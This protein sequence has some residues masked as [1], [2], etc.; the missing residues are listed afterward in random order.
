METNNQTVG[1]PT[2]PYK[3]SKKKLIISAVVGTFLIASIVLGATTNFFGMMMQNT[4]SNK[5]ATKQKNPDVTQSA[6]DVSDDLA[7][8]DSGYHDGDTYT[9]AATPAL[10]A[11]E[12]KLL[13][14]GTKLT[15]EFCAAYT[16]GTEPV[17]A[18]F[19]VNGTE[20]TTLT[21]APE[22]TNGTA[23]ASV[24]SEELSEFELADE[25][26]VSVT[27]TI[28]FKDIQ[29][30]SLSDNETTTSVTVPESA[31]EEDTTEKDLYLGTKGIWLGD[32]NDSVHAEVCATGTDGTESTQI[33]YNVNGIE[34]KDDMTAPADGECEDM[35]V[36]DLDQFSV[37]AGNTYTAS[38]ILDYSQSITESDENNGYAKDIT[39]EEKSDDQQSSKVDLY[40]NDEENNIGIEDEYFYTY[41]CSVSALEEVEVRFQTN[42]TKQVVKINIAENQC[43]KAAAKISEF[44]LSDNTAYTLDVTIDP[45]ETVTE[46]NENNNKDTY[47]FTTSANDNGENVSEK[48]LYFGDKG[49]WMDEENDSIYAEMCASG[50][51]GSE[52]EYVRINYNL[53]GIDYGYSQQAPEDGE[54]N[55]TKISGLDYFNMTNGDTYTITVTLD[56]YDVLEESDESNNTASTDATYGEEEASDSA[57]SDLYVGTISIEDTLLTIELG[58]KG[59]ADYPNKDIAKGS[60]YIYIDNELEWTYSLSTLGDQT[61]RTAGS[62]SLIQPQALDGSHEI[63]ACVYPDSSVGDADS[64][65]DCSSTKVGSSDTSDDE[66]GDE[67]DDYNDSDQ[68]VGYTDTDDEQGDT[69][70]DVDQQD[71]NTT[72]NTTSNA[73]LKKY[74]VIMMKFGDLEGTEDKDATMDYTGTLTSDS[75]IIKPVGSVL[76][77]DDDSY[78]SADLGFE[79]KNTVYDHW[80]GFIFL[81]YYDPEYANGATPT[82][83]VSVDGT[84]VTK[85]IDSLK[86]LNQTY[87]LGDGTDNAIKFVILND[88]KEFPDTFGDVDESDDAEDVADDA[89]DYIAD[90]IEEATDSIS[91]VD[92]SEGTDAETSESVDELVDAVTDVATNENTTND[93]VEDV[94]QTTDDSIA[95]ETASG[96]EITADTVDAVADDTNSA[97]TDDYDAGF[98]DVPADSWFAEYINEAEYYGIVDGYGDCNFGPNDYVTRAALV[99]MAINA[100][101]Y[102]VITD[103]AYNEYFYDL[104]DDAWYTDYINTAAYYEIISGYSNGNFGP[105]NIVNR[106]EGLKAIIVAS[107]VE[108]KG[109]PEIGTEAT[110]TNPFSDVD[111]Y[112]WYYTYVMEG[113]SAGI[114]SG[115]SGTFR[116]ADSL[117]RAEACK[118]IIE[119]MR[120]LATPTM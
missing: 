99:K 4:S 116:P 1:V 81:A 66:D 79:W 14:D 46:A 29:E 110:W 93:E 39:I 107:G 76:L 44:G 28:L 105:N 63:K 27:F 71:E 50:T 18:V 85:T 31:T 120:L 26:T 96:D 88:Y 25:S 22:A 104:A 82:F 113:H 12:V 67:A 55:E 84:Q 3:K 119:F 41:V 52:G 5:D 38:V 17:K 48:D 54:C 103:I 69:D 57:T 36:S 70:A 33:L 109:R 77:E 65:N 80:D 64:G 34:Y 16:D 100:F 24:Y 87:E 7:T 118:I 114:I 30:S 61:F 78:D 13:K 108:D 62:S 40:F 74:T 20:K 21:T 106:A 90:R 9:I 59:D 117:T 2:S 98:C 68:P 72:D 10:A 8:N 11:K 43:Q 86:A 75:L 101:E 97:A 47:T 53:T 19:N 115:D 94:A 92:V 51:T 91:K 95:A 35:S 15:G 89:Q 32:D 83:K 111:T 6:T 45:N 49:V 23:C 112:D 56:Y 58:N 73:W 102:D 37:E 60:L 42:S